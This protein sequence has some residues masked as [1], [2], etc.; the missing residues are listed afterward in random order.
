MV[1]VNEFILF[2][3]VEKY[4]FVEIDKCFVVGGISVCD[5]MIDWERDV[6]FCN[7]VN[8]GGGEFEI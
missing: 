1:F 3:D 8:G 6:Y 5:W 7:V 4:Y 2:E